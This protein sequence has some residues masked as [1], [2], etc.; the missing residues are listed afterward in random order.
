MSSILFDYEYDF[1]LDDEEGFR[2][3]ITGTVLSEGRDVG[4]LNYIF[5]SDDYLLKIN[6]EHLNH[7]TYT[8]IITF[9]YCEGDV[10]HGDIFISLDMVKFNADKFEN[11][12]NDE[13]CRVMIHGVHHL[14]GQ[15]DK[16]ESEAKEMRDKENLSLLQRPKSLIK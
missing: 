7:D 9:D 8:D 11:S 13:L 14:L 3:W 12:F 15:G 16:S 10:V 1:Q 5:C 6:M 4:E 2:Q